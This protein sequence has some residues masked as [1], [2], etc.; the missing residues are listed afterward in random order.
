MSAQALATYRFLIPLC[1]VFESLILLDNE[2]LTPAMMVG[3]AVVLI[4][5]TLVNRGRVSK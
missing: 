4:S 2:K 1:G 3:G 5:M